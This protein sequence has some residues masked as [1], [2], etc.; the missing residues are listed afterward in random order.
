MLKFFN[1]SSVEACYERIPR[2]DID[3]AEECLKQGDSLINKMREDFKRRSL[4]ELSQELEE[5]LA[6]VSCY[7]DLVKA[8]PDLTLVFSKLGILNEYGKEELLRH[9]PLQQLIKYINDKGPASDQILAFL[10]YQNE[11]V[12]DYEILES[13]TNTMES[14]D[15][16]L[17][18]AK[19]LL[20]GGNIIFLPY[21]KDLYYR[22][23]IVKAKSEFNF[24]IE[25]LLNE[26]K[27]YD[28][29]KKYIS[30]IEDE[31]V[32]AKYISSIED[33]D[34]KQ[35]LLETI[36]EKDNRMLV[37]E[38]FQREID[39]EIAS[40]DELVRT[41]ITEFFEDRLGENY[42]DE[43]RE[44]LQNVFAR[45]DVCFEGLYQ[46]ENG[47][48]NHV[49][50]R[51]S[52]SNKRKNS[53]NRNIGFLIHEY[54]H[55]FSLF[56]YSYTADGTCTDIEEGM[57][58][59]F[60]DLVV[61]HYISKHKCVILD[62][63]KVRID[64]P[65]FTYSGYDTENSW[66]RTML[67]GL[68]SKGRDIDAMAEYLLGNKNK[69]A[70]MIFGR[71][72]AES[73]NRTKFGETL[74]YT[75]VSELYYSK[76]LD[77]SNIDENSIY[78]RRNCILP[79][80]Q[81]QKRIGGKEDLVSAALTGN[82]YLASDIANQYFNG[83]KFYEVPEAEFERFMRLIDGKLEQNGGLGIIIDIDIWKN[84]IINTLTDQEIKEFSFEILERISAIWGKTINAGTNLERVMR[85]ALEEETRKIAEGQSIDISRAKR[86]VIMEKYAKCFTEN[87]ESNMYINDYINDF[88][89]EVSQ[90]EQSQ[91][92]GNKTI[93]GMMANA[94]RSFARTK[95][96]PEEKANARNLLNSLIR[97]PFTKGKEEK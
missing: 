89:F 66:A 74:I 51:T 86:N 36:K 48:A 16:D 37:I 87:N 70:E 32:R 97:T 21:V 90:A 25:D 80:Y 63:K 11:D 10:A 81:I 52:I 75:N 55:H 45:I 19:I 46:T 85:L 2:E 82:R 30:E 64:S 94:I 28:A 22:N 43:M 9:I 54:A 12:D 83:K 1:Y 77:F 3:L 58:D 47:K 60:S 35:A 34:M 6:D 67:A 7:G 27:I 76:T 84:E 78:Y 88:C 69:F 20:F 17:D 96:V 41:M 14:L 42:T 18:R 56:D 33:N 4:E 38:S 29:H 62:G 73:K 49:L 39:P 50:K 44:R 5:F 71:E 91:K 13:Q 53:I 68:E 59:T 61:N 92:A 31:N 95:G 15:S 93:L 40:L 65:Y 72:T 57:A 8:I 26:I 24:S 79:F 23:Q